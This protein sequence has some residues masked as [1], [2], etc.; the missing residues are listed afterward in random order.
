M[1]TLLFCCLI[2]LSLI[3]CNQNASKP[4]SN[5]FDQINIH[6][7][8]G[9]IHQHVTRGLEGYT[10]GK[11]QAFDDTIK[12]NGIMFVQSVIRLQE[13]S[14]LGVTTL[15]VKAYLGLIRTDLGMSTS[16]L[17][18]CISDAEDYHTLMLPR[19]KIFP[20][21]GM[22]CLRLAVNDSKNESLYIFITENKEN[23][24]LIIR[25]III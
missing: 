16:N 10:N 3:G 4:K 11:I 24:N 23:K 14:D 25:H 19:N 2:L 21:N 6:Y 20:I 9:V 13:S 5:T 7:P 18:R 12:E 8:V 17:K 22:Y 15:F 1:K